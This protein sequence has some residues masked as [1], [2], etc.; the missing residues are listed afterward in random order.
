M[1]CCDLGHLL[2]ASFRH[3]LT[4][5]GPAFGAQVDNPA[6][7]FDDIQIVLDDDQR[8]SCYSF[9]A[10]RR[11]NPCRDGDEGPNGFPVSC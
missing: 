11:L 10:Q 1:R 6:G 2:W 8:I 7:R 5:C 4:A 9:S 3:D